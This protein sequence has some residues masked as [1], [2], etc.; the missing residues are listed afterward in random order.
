MMSEYGG[1]GQAVTF[2]LFML[3]ASLVLYSGIRNGRRLRTSNNPVRRLI[4]QVAIILGGVLLFIL[5]LGLVRGMI[6][7][8]NPY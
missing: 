2:V 5:F 3:T 1:L 7:L 8:I 6:T 4:G